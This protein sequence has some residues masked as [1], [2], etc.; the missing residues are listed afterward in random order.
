MEGNNASSILR[1]FHKSCFNKENYLNHFLAEKELFKPKDLSKI[2]HR[3]GI[4]ICPIFE[5]FHN[6][7]F[8]KAGNNRLF[9]QSYQ[10]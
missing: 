7:C 4:N 6:L 1:N 5:K 2:L 9:R 3:V 10:K 8:D